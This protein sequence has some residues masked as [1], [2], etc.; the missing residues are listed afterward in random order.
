MQTCSHKAL[1]IDGDYGLMNSNG[2][3]I[4]KYQLIPPAMLNK[5]LCVQ[6]SVC[7]FVVLNVQGTAA[8][9]VCLCF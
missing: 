8:C 6:E 7:Y 4:I 3:D 9:L 2:S 5:Y 1:V